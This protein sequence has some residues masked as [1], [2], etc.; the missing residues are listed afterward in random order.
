[1]LSQFYGKVEDNV[2]RNHADVIIIGGGIIGCAIAYD[3]AK[4]NV[5]SLVIDK[6]S[7]VGTEASWAG[8]GILTSHASTH[9]PYPTLCR[10]SLALYPT[11]AEELRAETQIDI[12]LIQSGTLSVF[13][14]PAE[15]AGLIGLADRRVKR[16][17]STEVLTAEQAWQ[18]EPALSKS[19]TGAV[20]F[21]EDA[22][23]RNPKMVTA[24]AKAAAKLGA[25]FQ[26]G[27][28]VTDFIRVSE[29]G[30]EHVVG[31]VVNGE[32]YYADTFVI[33]AG[34]WTGTL[35]AQLDVP[36]QVEP[37]KGQI[38]LVETMPPLFERTIDGLGI[39]IVPRADGKILLGATVEFVGY[40][41]TATVDGAKQ[42]ID[43]GI[44]IA[45][46]LAQ[47]TFV[48][49][50]VGLRPYAKKGPLLGYLPGYDN[51][52]LASGHFK[53][54]ILL[55]PITGQLIAELITTGQPSLSLEPFQPTGV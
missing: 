25:E 1:L 52:V 20:L 35:T 10:A 43:A 12:E 28:P 48:Q 39:Y 44:A 36:I 51:V 41:K 26:V 54:G 16:G 45:P 27:N 15:A 22:Q 55:A 2:N 21:P 8:A 49:T 42:M 30:A 46:E 37:A 23:V 11:L 38:V 14:N 40:D 18:L 7:A 31:V 53:N 19:I 32:T 13:F 17:F 47:S 24:L 3:L 4:R 34:C 9:E 50:W 6:A 33:A 5:K 29:D